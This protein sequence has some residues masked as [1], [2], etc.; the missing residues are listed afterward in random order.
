MVFLGVGVLERR[1]YWRWYGGS[2]MPE[3]VFR[4][5]DALS[6]SPRPPI[7]PPSR[8]YQPGGIGRT[9][10]KERTAVPRAQLVTDGR[11]AIWVPLAASGESLPLAISWQYDRPAWNRAPLGPNTLSGIPAATE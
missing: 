5:C 6:P 7:D 9:S 2:S 4:R 8:P 3:S 10:I 1:T 11:M